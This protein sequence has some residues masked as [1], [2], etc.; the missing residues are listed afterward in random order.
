MRS[1]ILYSGVEFEKEE[2]AIASKYFTCTNRR[3]DIQ[4]DDLVIGRYSLAFWYADQEKDFKQVGAKLINSYQQHRYIADLQNYM[5]DL[6]DLTPRTWT[7]PV[8]LPENMSF[9]VKGETYSRKNNWKQDMFAPDK[10]TAIEIV[11]RL[12]NDSLIGQGNIYIRQYQPMITYLEG[13]NGMPITKEFRFF[14]AYGQII[15]GGFYWQNY[16]DQ[17]NPLPD[18]AEVPLSFLQEVI[19]RVGSQSNFFVIDVGQAITGEWF[20]VEL[21][22]GQQSGL[23]C[24]DPETLY[25]G[26]SKV[27]SQQQVVFSEI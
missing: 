25:S 1:I 16:I 18:P 2:L 9:V 7:S 27:I 26:L 8:D 10:K 20:V 4:A 6:G 24:N 17:I 22:E 13:V 5:M 11:G 3:P 12:M 21:N 23:S 19:D 15:S 14:V